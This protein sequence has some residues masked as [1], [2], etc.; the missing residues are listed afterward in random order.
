MVTCSVFSGNT[1]KA[2]QTT[3]LT[4]EMMISGCSIDNGTAIIEGTLSHASGFDKT[5]NVYASTGRLAISPFH[6][7]IRVTGTT[8][9]G[10]MDV[11][12]AGHIVTLK[13]DAALVVVD[14]SQNLALASNFTTAA[15]STLTLRCDGATWWEVGRVN[16]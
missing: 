5:S 7:Y 8:N 13:F 10:G 3:G 15:G 4:R 9:I 2:I 1:P 11:T 12:Y 16:T 14:A 6:D